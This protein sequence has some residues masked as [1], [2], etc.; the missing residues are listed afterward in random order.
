METFVKLL[1]MVVYDE[2]KE[3]WVQELLFALQ[4]SERWLYVQG[5]VHVDKADEMADLLL[6]AQ[7]YSDETMQTKGQLRALWIVS[8]FELMGSWPLCAQR[9]RQF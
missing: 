2:R 1:H 3:L 5:G 9:W 8:H 7:S 4:T 6:W